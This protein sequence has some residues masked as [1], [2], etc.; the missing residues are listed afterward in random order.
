MNAILQVLVSATPN[1]T[2][3]NIYRDIRKTYSI[4]DCIYSGVYPLYVMFYKGHANL[5]VGVAASTHLAVVHPAYF[6]GGP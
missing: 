2:R 3:S 6:A 4:S 5:V 1:R